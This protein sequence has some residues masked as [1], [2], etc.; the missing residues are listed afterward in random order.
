MV[1][2][3]RAL[4]R[5]GHEVL[6]AAPPDAAGRIESAGVR[7]T[8]AGRP[9]R[10]CTAD[11]WGRHPELRSLPPAELPDQM[12]PRMFGGVAAPA[13][14]DDLAPVAL[15]W[16]PDLVVADAAE[17][18]GPIV[19][20]ELGVP[21]VTKS[22]GALLPAR[23][24]AAAA[25][26]VAPL[27]RS[28]G[29]EPRPYAGC[30]DHLYLDI[31]PPGLQPETADRVPRRQLL[32]PVAYDGAGGRAAADPFVEDRSRGPLVYV[33]LGTV[34]NSPEPLHRAVA[35]LAPFHIRLLVTVGPDG[36]PDALGAQPDHI[37]VERYVP[38]TLVFE[39]ADLVV[40]TAAPVPFWPPWT[41]AYPSCA[42]RKGPTSS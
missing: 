30:Y 17:L 38:Q 1:P 27:W 3:A 29:L 40:P 26:V 25:E 9:A 24:L 33:T 13:M 15:D 11:F 4:L 22:F 8:P 16:R 35:A 5:C 20:A 18:A 42:S 21:G 2:L 31:Y 7:T 28:R 36:D 34:F 6:W 12:F 37:R 19:A 32:R 23:R 39:H 41:R 10:E 14:L